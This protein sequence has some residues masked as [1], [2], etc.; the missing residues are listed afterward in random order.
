[1]QALPVVEQGMTGDA[2]K[3]VQ[4]LCGARGATVRIDGIFGGATAVAVRFVQASSD[5][6]IDAIVGPLTWPKLLGV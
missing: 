4:A 5:L 3:T 2:V 6:K 1:M